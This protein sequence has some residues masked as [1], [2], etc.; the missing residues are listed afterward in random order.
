MVMPDLF[1][2]H[3]SQAKQLAK[4]GLSGKDIVAVALRAMGIEASA[5]SPTKVITSR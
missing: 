4:A 5:A 2:D 3:D 1:I